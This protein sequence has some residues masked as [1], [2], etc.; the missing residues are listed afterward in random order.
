LIPRKGLIN[1]ILRPDIQGQG[2]H[3]AWRPSRSR[4]ELAQIFAR[5]SALG[6]RRDCPHEIEESGCPDAFRIL[7]QINRFHD[8]QALGWNQRGLIIS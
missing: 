3:S 6:C 4:S 5:E 1:G 8:N 2:C 7:A